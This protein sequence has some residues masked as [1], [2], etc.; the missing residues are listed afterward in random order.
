MTSQ[1]SRILLLRVSLLAC[2]KML[3]ILRL[4]LFILRI[5]ISEHG[6]LAVV[7]FLLLLL[8]LLLS[9]VLCYLQLSN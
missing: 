3:F 9:D 2:F 4:F 6:E 1:P 5:L 7:V 8:L